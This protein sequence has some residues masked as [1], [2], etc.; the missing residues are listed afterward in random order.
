M[1]DRA[2]EEKIQFGQ[3]LFRKKESEKRRYQLDK[4]K[5]NIFR[6]RVEIN[7]TCLDNLISQ[8]RFIKESF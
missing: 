7:V 8:E 3:D 1:T 2:P 5:D 6:I 4:R